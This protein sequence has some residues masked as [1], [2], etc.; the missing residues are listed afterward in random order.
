MGEE[1]TAPNPSSQVGMPEASRE[2]SRH[3]ALDSE[4]LF[5]I[6]ASAMDAII[7]IDS[8]QRIV[9][10]NSAAEKMFHVSADVALGQPIDLF[11]PERYRAAHQTHVPNFGAT[12]VTKRRMGALGA[13]Y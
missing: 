5:S 2:Q 9:L 12:L 4:A 8:A 7:T 10:F 1:M 11:I 6:I 13:I 3:A